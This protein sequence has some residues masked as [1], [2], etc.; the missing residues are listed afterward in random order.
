MIAQRDGNVGAVAVDEAR[1]VD[2][3]DTSDGVG[4]KEGLYALWRNVQQ[5][6][7][8]KLERAEPP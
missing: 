2:F 1:G 5:C 3:A 8:K 7:S 6:V 4:G